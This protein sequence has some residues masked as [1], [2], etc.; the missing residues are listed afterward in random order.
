MMLNKD[1]REQ[2]IYN[3]LYLLSKGI[4]AK[5]I[6]FSFSGITE[7]IETELY[8]NK[9][10]NSSDYLLKIKLIDRKLNEEIKGLFEFVEKIENW[11]EENFDIDEDWILAKK[12]ATKLFN[13]VGFKDEGYDSTGEEIILVDD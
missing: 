12:W 13:K 1:Y 10:Q 6:D 2:N 7:E 9:S 5:G 4:K 3:F 11:Q 8:L